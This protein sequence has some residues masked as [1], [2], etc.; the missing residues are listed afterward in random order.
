M[1]L[2]LLE[3]TTVELNTLLASINSGQGTLGKLVTD[4]SL[5]VEAHAASA[6][7][8]RILEN[9]E[10]N[11]NQYLRHLKLIDFF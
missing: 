1:N 2:D 8:R 6:A 9:F 11:P 10:E 3:T 5:Y 4:D 7:L